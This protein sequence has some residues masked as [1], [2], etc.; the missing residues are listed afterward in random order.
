MGRLRT[1]ASRGGAVL[2][3]SAPPIGVQ[4]LVDP[5]AD[6]GGEPL[7]PAGLTDRLGRRKLIR[8][9]SVVEP[10][11]RFT[12]EASVWFKHP[13]WIPVGWLLCLG[14]LGAVWFAARP[15]EPWHATSHALL[16]VGFAL[17]A[18]HLMAR[19]RAEA[20]SE[21]LRQTLD[22]NEQLQQTVEDMHSQVQ[23]L[24]ERVD[25]AER[26]LAQHRDASRLDAPPR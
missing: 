10:S 26:L 23:E 6:D 17:G 24:K 8:P 7:L 19:R 11:P 25:F 12:P 2:P 5:V 20:P 14:N 9:S 13:A 16:A 21:Q 18:R 15:A 22:Q 4:S 1:A 3:H